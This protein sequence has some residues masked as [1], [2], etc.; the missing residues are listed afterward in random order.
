MAAWSGIP[1]VIGPASLDGV[2]DKIIRGADVG[3]W[4]APR[5]SGLSARKLWIAFGLPSYGKIVVDRG[6][7]AA[8]CERGK[9]L[10]TVGVAN[11]TGSF[12]AGQA[13]EV[14]AT[15]GR[16]IGKGIVRVGADDPER[17]RPRASSTETTW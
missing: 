10:L 15:D 12:I 16:M 8:I 11:Q 5:H 6:A 2:V 1:T 7:E 13:V 9:S 4:V 14:Y 3:T 17:R